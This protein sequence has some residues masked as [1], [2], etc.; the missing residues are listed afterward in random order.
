M[1]IIKSK[2]PLSYLHNRR[3]LNPVIPTLKKKEP[4]V[5]YKAPGQQ[6]DFF[7]IWQKRG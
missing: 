6:L 3:Y 2:K 1:Y 4:K 7:T 5:I